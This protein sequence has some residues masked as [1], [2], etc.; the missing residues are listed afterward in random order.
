MLL[1]QLEP[2][3]TGTRHITLPYLMEHFELSL[4]QLRTLFRENGV[5]HIVEYVN[6]LRFQH[7]A[8]ANPPTQGSL[9]AWCSMYGVSYHFVRKFTQKPQL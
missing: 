3:I 9:V 5:R 1:K 6:H 8:K 4:R 7:H 2:V